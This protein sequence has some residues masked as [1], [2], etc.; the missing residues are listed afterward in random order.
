MNDEDF[1]NS[2]ECWESDPLVRGSGSSGVGCFPI[3]IVIVVI[4]LYFFKELIK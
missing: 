3:L 4:G 1:F 2:R